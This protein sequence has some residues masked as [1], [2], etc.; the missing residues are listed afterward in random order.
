MSDDLFAAAPATTFLPAPADSTADGTTTIASAAQ[1]PA[2]EQSAPTESTAA[3][4]QE[5]AAVAAEASII[6]QT[7][8]PPPSPSPAVIVA[9]ACAGKRCPTGYDMID[10]GDR[11]TCRPQAVQQ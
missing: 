1:A 7:S 4:G 10:R 5:A 8:P 11:R 2:L 6:V 9:G 3:T